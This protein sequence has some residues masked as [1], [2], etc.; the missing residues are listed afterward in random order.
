MPHYMNTMPLYD[1]R[2]H[3]PLGP[4]LNN[5]WIYMAYTFKVLIKRNRAQVMSA[6]M[7]QV[8]EYAKKTRLPNRTH[9]RW[10]GSTDL[11]S[12]DEIMGM[13]W[14]NYWLA[15][16]VLE[17]LSP[18]GFYET[19]PGPLTLKQ[20][21]EAWVPRFPWMLPF[22][23]ASARADNFIDH[24]VWSACLVF[25]AMTFHER[26]A[27]G[28]LRWW[29]QLNTMSHSKISRAAIRFWVSRHVKRGITLQAMLTLEPREY[30]ELAEAAQ[31]MPWV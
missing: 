16:E 6:L 22:V 4:L 18:F 9:S 21:W 13:C 20:K 23:R 11:T 8:L 1:E 19:R 25:D 29:L 31:G 5:P 2:Y 26:D 17:A 24:L 10:P 27:G 7:P 3:L 30:P 28:R 12:H 14:L 15:R